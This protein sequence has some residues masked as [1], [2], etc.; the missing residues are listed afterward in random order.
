LVDRLRE[1]AQG[2]VSVLAIEVC[3]LFDFHSSPVLL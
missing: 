1:L 3:D 2:E